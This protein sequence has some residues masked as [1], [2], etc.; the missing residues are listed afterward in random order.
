MEK[1]ESDKSN[2]I[3]QRYCRDFLHHKMHI[4]KPNALTVKVVEAYTNAVDRIDLSS[5]SFM[6]SLHVHVETHRVKL[7]QLV[8]ILKPISKEDLETTMHLNASELALTCLLSSVETPLFSSSNILEFAPDVYSLIV[9]LLFEFLHGC[10]TAIGQ[11][12]LNVNEMEKWCT[13]YREIVR[14]NI[15]CVHNSLYR[16]I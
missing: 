14:P 13:C 8:Q 2:S 10:A 3:W 6:V 5:S 11:E 16:Y 9:F 15:M 1:M 4:K 12:T 7:P